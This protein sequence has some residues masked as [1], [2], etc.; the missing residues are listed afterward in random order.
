APFAQ[1]F[2]G[3]QRVAP[4]PGS[5]ASRAM[6]LAG[7]MSQ[8]SLGDSRKPTGMK[9]KVHDLATT[10]HSQ[11]EELGIEKGNMQSIKSEQA[12]STSGMQAMP[13]NLGS[14]G[15]GRAAVALALFALDADR[16]VGTMGALSRTGWASAPAALVCTVVALLGVSDARNPTS[17]VPIYT[18]SD[19]D[20]GAERH[21]ALVLEDDATDEELGG[22]RQELNN[23][24]H[25]HPGRGQMPLVVGSMTRKSLN[26]LLARHKGRVKF[27]QEHM[28]AT[29]SGPCT[30]DGTCVQSPN[31]P[32]NYGGNQMCTIGIDEANAAPIVVEAFNT[33]SNSDYLIVNGHMWA[34]IS[35]PCT[36]DG[37]C[38]QSPNHP[39]NY[40]GNQ[41]CT[42]GIDE[43]N[44]A[45]IVVEAFNTES[46]SDYLIVNGVELEV[47]SDSVVSPA[48]S[49]RPCDGQPWPAARGVPRVLVVRSPNGQSSCEGAYS[50]AVEDVGMPQGMPVWANGKGRWLYSSPVG[51]WRHRR[52]PGPGEQVHQLFGPPLQPG[53]AHG[54]HARP[55]AQN[56]VACGGSG[57]Q[58]G[59]G[60]RCHGDGLDSP[61]R[62]PHKGQGLQCGGGRRAPGRRGPVARGGAAAP[63]E[64]QAEPRAS[65]L[66]SRASRPRG[67]RRAEGLP[68][69]P[70]ASRTRASRCAGAAPELGRASGSG[71][72]G[73]PSAGRAGRRR[74]RRLEEWASPRTLV[75]AACCEWPR[76]A[77]RAACGARSSRPC[78]PRVSSP[79]GD[80]RRGSL[81]AV[82]LVRGAQRRSENSA[83]L[84]LFCFC[85]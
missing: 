63:A 3:A 76:A 84:C 59:L 20:V 82:G 39:S 7:G 66:R 69:D 80:C 2:W 68:T 60:R 19:V 9:G 31:H 54:G 34:T 81:R 78:W 46:N 85:P 58:G 47:A 43:V 29:I 55:G 30:L 12:T 37:T 40:G 6:E 75:P 22:I 79:V 67:P 51:T 53:L 42:I 36:L 15:F 28:W 48:V 62:V 65:S 4:V 35:G 25:S 10:L 73:G 49:Y 57:V 5:Q 21:W 8:Q 41:M 27:V 13:R 77:P 16:S 56:L 33:E 83:K 50:L 11:S 18:T 44:A 52:L 14:S 64:P 61:R 23:G 32:S 26:A 71:G 72:S 70:A 45:P 1:P 17:D 24:Q 38:V 74:R